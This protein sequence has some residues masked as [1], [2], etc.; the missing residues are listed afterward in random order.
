M[1]VKQRG[2]QRTRKTTLRSERTRAF[3]KY[4]TEPTLLEMSG[5]GTQRIFCLSHNSRCHFLPS[6]PLAA[7]LF[8]VFLLKRT[9][10]V[11]GHVLFAFLLIEKIQVGPAHCKVL[12]QVVGFSFFDYQTKQAG[13][14]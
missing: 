7:R 8:L 5:N 3:K 11:F 1:V 13:F 14:V 12:A 2:Q 4:L 6:H 10:I 9:S